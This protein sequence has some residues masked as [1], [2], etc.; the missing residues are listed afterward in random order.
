MSA[1]PRYP[2]YRDSG[3]PGIESIPDGWD[4][5]PFRHLLRLQ[6]GQVDPRATQF[7]DVPLVAPNHIESGTGRH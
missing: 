7:A 2:S 5:A 1:W 3:I 4:A 6:N